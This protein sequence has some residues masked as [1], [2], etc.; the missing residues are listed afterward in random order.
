[1]KPIIDFMESS[2]FFCPPHSAVAGNRF[3]KIACLEE[4][5]CNFLMPGGVMIRNL[6]RVLLEGT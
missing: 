1:M 3:L 2:N 5:M 4:T 6:K